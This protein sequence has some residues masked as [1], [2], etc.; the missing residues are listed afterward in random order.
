ML[1]AYMLQHGSGGLRARTTQPVVELIDAQGVRALFA[2]ECDAIA[3]NP[4]YRVHDSE[5]IR[6]LFHPV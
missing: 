6:C 1:L 5:R 3:G 2:S 4:I